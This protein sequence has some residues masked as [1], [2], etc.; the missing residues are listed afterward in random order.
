MQALADAR[1]ER[2]QRRKGQL[3][4]INQ[5]LGST[6]K[7]YRVYLRYD[8]DG[9]SDHFVGYVRAAMQGSYFHEDGTKTLCTKLTPKQLAELLEAK[10]RGQLSLRGGIDERWAATLIDRLGSF[11]VIRELETMDKPPRP[12]IGVRPTGGGNEISVT[13][14]SDG[15]KHTILLSIAMLAE[16][17]VPLVI[18]QP[19][20]DL[21]NAY[22]FDTLVTTL[23]A[24]KERRQIIL[25]THNA[26]IAVLGDSELLVPMR[27]SGQTGESYDAGSIDA[28]PTKAAVQRVLEGGRLAFD[29]R[30]EIYSH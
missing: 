23:R 3:T 15:Q 16:S 21:D 25:V 24:A 13:E 30:R 10:D 4:G 8:N 28:A 26:N 7:D 17:S 18:D 14:L 6:I 19:E 5:V 2:T 12:V 9:L 22:V 29:R 27:R 20:D 11:K 1:A